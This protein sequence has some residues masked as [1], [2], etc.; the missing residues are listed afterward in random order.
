MQSNLERFDTTSIQWID[1]TLAAKPDMSRT[2]LARLACERL[3][4]RAPNGRYQRAGC[5]IALRRLQE[6]GLIS[7]PSP[8]QTPLLDPE[9]RQRLALYDRPQL[10]CSL[11]ELG[12]IELLPVNGSKERMHLWR[13]MMDSWHPLKAGNLCGAQIRYLIQ[14]AKGG[15]VGGLS[16][17]S[18][19][20]RLAARDQWIGW[21]EQMRAERLAL[22][23]NNSRFL[24]L[25]QVQVQNLASRVL[26]LVSQR[27]VDDWEAIYALRPVL[28]ET[29]VDPEPYRGTCYR[30][31]NW[32][33]VG[34]TT[35]RGRQDDGDLTRP[36]D[37]YLLP[38]RP[39]FRDILGGR[40]PQLKDWAEVEFGRA[41]LGDA[42][43]QRRLY[44]LARIFYSN[45]QANI[46]EACG[47]KAA[48]KAAYRF[49]QHPAARM[50]KTLAGHYAATTD[51]IRGHH[52]VILAAQDTTSL[53]YHSHPATVGLGHI[54]AKG[55][56]GLLVHDTMA[57]T[58]EGV[59][60][61]LID[62][63]CWAR[64]EKKN[65]TVSES[66]KW[67][68]SFAATEQ[69]KKACPQT[70]II[71]S[72]GDREA[73]F[74]E[75][76]SRV[77][78]DGAQLLIR[79]QHRRELVGEETTVWLHMKRSP[80]SGTL[81][82][83]V[84]A[85]PGQAARTATLAVHFDKVTLRPPANLA[86]QQPVAVWAVLAWEKAP[87]AGIEPLEWLLF[88]TVA[89]EN[90]AAACERIAW[91]TKRWGIEIFHRTLKS[92]CKIEDRQLGTHERLSSCLALD[93]VVAWRVYYLSK[94]GREEPDAPCTVFFAEEEWQALAAFVN[95]T[96]TPPEK[97]PTL[98]EAMYMVAK[99]GGYL[100][101]KND[102]PPGATTIWRGLVALGWIRMAWVAFVTGH[103]PPWP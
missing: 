73:D 18:P 8:R 60:L 28:L 83:K 27:I 31:A 23:V 99:I 12:E 57:F 75:L 87:P 19:A 35:G 92:G 100:G 50:E 54:D 44:L 1:E 85:R 21:P 67:L 20:W 4:W 14:T 40:Q 47:S 3:N 2:Q 69:V 88:T 41:A 46:P 6:L 66:V 43:L 70:K 7:L 103:D 32:I 63:Q 48:I 59:P 65:R 51:R 79:A 26:G 74:Y 86:K 58:A 76:F 53:N 56:Q 5:A 71:V 33:P 96:S 30:A 95:K 9:R 22:V 10:A 64:E 34:R 68:K 89:V 17:S 102:G 91:Y 84:P 16:F 90:F 52:G 13:R 77:R 37:V 72:V 81:E 49:F 82:V 80:V 62:V 78:P 45:P 24:I 15:L 93:M 39:D 98:G 97:P 61:G 42:R 25:Q 38:L 101:R 11:L 29:F 94:Q 55:T 36:K